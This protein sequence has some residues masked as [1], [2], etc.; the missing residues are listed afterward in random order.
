MKVYIG[1]DLGGSSVKFGYGNKKLGLLAFGNKNHQ[2]KG[3][4]EI[5]GMLAHTVIDLKKKISP[6]NYLEAITIGSPGYIN[7][8]DGRVIA[9]CPNLVNWVDANPKIFLEEKFAMPVIAENDAALMTYGEAQSNTRKGKAVLGITIGSGIGS[10]FV[11]NNNIY[12]S[13]FDAAMELGHNIVVPQGRKC[14]CGKT[15]CLEAYASVPNI[16]KQAQSIL[17]EDINVAN[18]LA[19]QAK[20]QKVAGLLRSVC[21]KIGLATANAISLLDPEFVVIGGGMTEIAN[22]RIEP[23]T[24]STYAYL[25]QYQ[26]RNIRIER[27]EFKNQAGV[28]GGICLAE[29]N[30]S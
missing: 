10:G 27:A 20:D 6:D 25:N 9:N 11:F 17:D 29:E 23:I 4:D 26:R 14:S 30:Y 13:S 12:H 2:N 15:G 28:W 18:L 24:E 1:L 22:F 16:E 19:R 21:D 5:Y 3:R 7:H 8:I